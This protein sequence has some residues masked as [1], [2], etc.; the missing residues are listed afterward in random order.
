[1]TE[2]LWA[3]TRSCSLNIT[4]HHTAV[5]PQHQDGDQREGHYRFNGGAARGDDAQVTAGVLEGG[6]EVVF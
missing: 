2:R 5:R 4:R 3:R 6:L 1:M